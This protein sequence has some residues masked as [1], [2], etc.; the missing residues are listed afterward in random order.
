MCGMFVCVCVCVCGMLICFVSALDS[1]EMGRHKLPIISFL[2]SF[3]SV[4]CETGLVLVSFMT[5]LSHPFKEDLRALPVC[6]AFLP[7]TV[8]CVMSLNCARGYGLMILNTSDFSRRKPVA[9]V[10]IYPPICLFCRFI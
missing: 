5:G 6:H 2:R 1:G 7:E 3:S 4:S 9:V 10:A 8:G